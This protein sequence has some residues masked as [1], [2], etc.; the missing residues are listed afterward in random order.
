MDYDREAELALQRLTAGDVDI[1]QLTNAWSRSYVE[2]IVKCSSSLLT[3]TLCTLIH[4]VAL[5]TVVR[6]Y[7][8]DLYKR[9]RGE[10]C[11]FHI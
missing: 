7:I 10:H 4:H 5:D 11:G 8:M 2:V 6:I 3:C 1:N 9:H